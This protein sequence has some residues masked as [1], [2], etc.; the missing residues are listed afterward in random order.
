[1]G[2][3]QCSGRTAC[4]FHQ[5]SVRVDER[6]GREEEKQRSTE[7]TAALSQCG[8]AVERANPPAEQEESDHDT[9]NSE[10]DLELH[11]VADTKGRRVGK[12][13]TGHF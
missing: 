13:K 1:M 8:L 11:D 2:C 6:S 7:I 10:V 9:G 5:R 4:Q 3:D 12:S